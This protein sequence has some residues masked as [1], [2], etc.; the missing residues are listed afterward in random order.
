MSSATTQQPVHLAIS[1]KVRQG[2][3]EQFDRAL[4]RFVRESTDFRGVTGVHVQRPPSDG[5][6][7]EF[8]IVR[9]FLSEEH[10]RDFYDAELYRHYEAETAALREEPPVFRALQGIEAF[11]RGGPAAPP[12]RWKMAV[13]TWMGVFPASALWSQ[14]VGSRLT[15]LHPLAVTGVVTL[16]VVATVVWCAMPL[17][18]KAFRPWLRN[19]R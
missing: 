3:E 11:F 15:M 13:V 12:P 2:K 9:S 5:D 7:R 8:A 1:V 17:L 18:T 10:R 16:L 4:T 19:G 6:A 14:T